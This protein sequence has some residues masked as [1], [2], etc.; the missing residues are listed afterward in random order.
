[1]SNANFTRAVGL[2]FKQ[3]KNMA[4]VAK[5][6]NPFV[7]FA[8]GFLF[9]PIGVG[10]YLQSAA[11]FALALAMVLLGAF[12]TAGIAAPVFWC[13]CGA[14]AFVRIRHSNAAPAQRLDDH[15][16]ASPERLPFPAAT[17]RE[18]QSTY[19]VIDV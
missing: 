14:W 7:G 6:K 3:A 1:M 11:D 10:L 17:R 19:E 12:F 2:T 9:G 16:P 15:R 8:V 13:L 5:G 18:S 4:P